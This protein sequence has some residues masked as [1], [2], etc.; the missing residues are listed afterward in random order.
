MELELDFFL[1]FFAMA[2][3]YGVERVLP[4]LGEPCVRREG[5][6]GFVRAGQGVQCRS[7]YKN[8]FGFDSDKTFPGVE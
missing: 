7:C 8:E 2:R 4:M 1:G 5:C 3:L 6:C